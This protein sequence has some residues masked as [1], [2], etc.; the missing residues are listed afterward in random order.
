MNIENINI[1]G[2]EESIRASKFPKSV[3]TEDCDFEITNTVKKLGRADCGS[4]HDCFSKGIVVQ[5]DVTAPQYWWLQFGRYHFADIISSQ[6][7]MHKI[8]KMNIKQQCNKYVHPMIIDL[9]QSMINEYND[10]TL[11]SKEEKT[12]LFNRIVASC[13]MGLMLTARITTNYLQ[14][15]TM[16]HQR[17]NHKLQEWHLFCGVVEELPKF[18]ELML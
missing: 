9:V 10:N 3:D 15:K 12:E 18:K 14:L 17:K 13:P 8:T 4:G 11:L 5:A 2:L 6:S 7:K 16:Y 1:Y